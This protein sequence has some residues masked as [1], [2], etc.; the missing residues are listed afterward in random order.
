MKHVT[1][2]VLLLCSSSLYAQLAKGT[3]VIGG[4]LGYNSQHDRSYDPNGYPYSGEN[5]S[6]T[7]SPKAG[8]FISDRSV[9]GLAL[10][11]TAQ[12]SDAVY[13]G[14]GSLGKTDRKLFSVI[15]YFRSYKSLGET[16]A[17]FVQAE[18]SIGF[19]TL[20]FSGTPYDISTYGFAVRPGFNLFLSRKWALEATFGSLAY[21]STKQSPEDSKSSER[22]DK[23]GFNFNMSTL[24]LGAQFFIAR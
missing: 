21:E 20:K 17:F 22:S 6:T 14:I 5:T 19:G 12:T 18:A 3:V 7:I 9:V 24:S 8:F 23:F 15:P 16:A 11:Y 10:S 13:A 2:I 1:I 4:S